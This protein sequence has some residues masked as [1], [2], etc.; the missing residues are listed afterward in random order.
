MP[1]PLS[2]S[3]GDFT[4]F[5]KYNTK[6]GRWYVRDEDGADVEVINPKLIFDFDNI[7]TGW[8]FFEEGVG[9]EK[10]WDPKGGVAPRPSGPKKWRRGFEVT[11]YGTD[12]AYGKVIGE[13]EFSSTATNCIAAIIDMYKAYEDESEA[14]AGKLPYFQCTGVKPVQSKHGTNYEPQFKLLSWVE[15]AKIPGLKDADDAPEPGSFEP[16]DEVPF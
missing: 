14:N 5:I 1:L 10:V 3:D 15:R 8:L 7:K 16:D 4:P 11:V 12:K 13:R 9:P 2:T 6:A